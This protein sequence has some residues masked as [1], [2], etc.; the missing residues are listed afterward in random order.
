METPTPGARASRAGLRLSV[1]H[2]QGRASIP[3][4]EAGKMKGTHSAMLAQNLTSTR[5]SWI[6][7]RDAADLSLPGR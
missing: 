5:G 2:H 4:M 7:L 3:G 6:M 1:V